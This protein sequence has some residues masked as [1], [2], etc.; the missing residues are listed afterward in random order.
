MEEH[1][2]KSHQDD[3]VPLVVIKVGT[4]TLMKVNAETGDQ[5]V[6][7]SAM[8]AIVETV[9]S[10]HQMGYGVI[11]VTSA[12]VGFGCLKLNLRERPK[13]LS[14]KQAAA[15]AIG[16]RNNVLVLKIPK[17]FKSTSEWMLHQL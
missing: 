15:D 4:S 11:I 14:L 12:A 5:R 13:T 16:S 9:T 3:R 8:G 7:L 1:L 6:N 10:L 17:L 2:N